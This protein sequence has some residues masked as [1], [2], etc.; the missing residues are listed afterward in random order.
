MK[1]SRVC[2]SG[3]VKIGLAMICIILLPA[4]ASPAEVLPLKTLITKIQESYEGTKDL[5]ASFSQEVTMKSMNRTE[6]EEGV[7]YFKKPQKM[8][9]NYVKPKKKK[10]VINPQ[11]TWFYLP[12]DRVVYLQDTESVLKSKLTIKFLSGLGNIQ[13]D[14]QVSFSRSE[15][16]DEEGNY[17]LRLVPKSPDIGMENI[18]LTIDKDNFQVAQFSF[19]DAYGNTSRIRFRNV[20]INNGL[21]DGTFTFKTPPGTEVFRMP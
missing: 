21:P 16:L 13:E 5:K 18:S 1:L 12:D 19:T 14:F 10:L 3:T 4:P 11:N 17:L 2:A 8:L 9:W 7:F 20:S 6:R 15:P